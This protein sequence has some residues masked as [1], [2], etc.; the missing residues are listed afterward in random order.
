MNRR[1]LGQA[2]TGLAVADRPDERGAGRC[3]QREFELNEAT[4]AQSQSAI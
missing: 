3:C 1:L 4:L 2:F